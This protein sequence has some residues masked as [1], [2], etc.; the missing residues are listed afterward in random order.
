VGYGTRPKAA[1]L[2]MGSTAVCCRA[3]IVPPCVK[4][5]VGWCCRGLVLS[6]TVTSYGDDELV[7]SCDGASEG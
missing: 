2:V 7:L 6:V 3:V 1:D 4:G 5:I